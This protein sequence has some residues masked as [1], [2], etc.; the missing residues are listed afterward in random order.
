MHFPTFTFTHSLETR[1]A[2]G[3]HAHTFL[4]SARVTRARELARTGAS[5]LASRRSRSGRLPVRTGGAVYLL[6]NGGLAH[7]QGLREGDVE[8]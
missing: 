7:R 4:Q 5:W 3:I 8:A 6:R 2:F 1:G